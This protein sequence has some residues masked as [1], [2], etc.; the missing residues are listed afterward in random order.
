MSL[1]VAWVPLPRLESKGGAPV[2]DWKRA[3]DAALCVDMAADYPDEA[4]HGLLARCSGAGKT[5]QQRG[6]R[7]AENRTHHVGT[8]PAV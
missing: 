8:V 3:D 4:I 6:D 1:Y 7:Y 5:L 2:A